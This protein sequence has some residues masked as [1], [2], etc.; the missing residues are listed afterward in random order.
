MSEFKKIKIG[1]KEYS[2]LKFG[3]EGFEMSPRVMQNTREDGILVKDEGILPFPWHGVTKDKDGEYILLPSVELEDISLISSKY[4]DKALNLVN[5]IAKGLYSAPESFL[6]LSTGVFPLYRIYIASGCDIVLLPPDAGEILTLS[7]TPLDIDRSVRNLLTPSLERGYTLVNEMAQLLYFALS[8]RFPYEK[9]EVRG[10]G[11]KPY[12]LSYYTSMRNETSSFIMNTLLMGEKA[13]RRICLNNTARETL[14]Y[15]LDKTETLS[16]EYPS[17]EESERIWAMKKSE[18]TKVFIEA[19][20]KKEKK[21][22]Q[23]TFLRKKGVIT[24][25]IIVVV[26]I[27]GYLVGNFL[28]QKFRAPYTKD[29]SPSEIISYTIE[30]QNELDAASLNEGYKKDAAQY[31]EVTTLYILNKTR[32][33]YESK[34]PFIPLSEWKENGE[35]AIENDTFVYGVEILNIIDEG[36][37]KYTAELTWYTPYGF[38]DED[39]ETYEE[40]EGYTRTFVYSVNEHFTFEYNKRGWWQCTSSYF[41]DD[42]L[43]DVIYIPNVTTEEL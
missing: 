23:R 19:T 2:A 37:G 26:S 7:R 25:A 29:L 5:K 3:L 24:L 10:S 40:K 42:K 32:L 12:E 1:E 38:S 21:A 22:S 11:F 36:D 14:K 15:F 31:K 39:E 41:S 43:E 33:A 28:Y 27:V 17:L 8:G 4:R 6:D 9:S 34:A 13:Q 16:W 18:G 30:K 35:G 20:K